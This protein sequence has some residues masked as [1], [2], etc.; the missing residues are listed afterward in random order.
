MVNPELNSGTAIKTFQLEFTEESRI[1]SVEGKFV[2]IR[3]NTNCEGSL[4]QY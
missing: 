1:S 2:D 4:D 3:K